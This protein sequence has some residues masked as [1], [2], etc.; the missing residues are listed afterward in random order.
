MSPRIAEELRLRRSVCFLMEGPRE[1]LGFCQG[2]RVYLGN[3]P[4]VDLP[5]TKGHVDLKG[6]LGLVTFGGSPRGE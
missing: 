1:D 2:E 3:I 4:R 5:C 6:K